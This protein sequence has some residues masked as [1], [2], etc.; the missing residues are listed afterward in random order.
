[1]QWRKTTVVVV[2][3]V[4][5]HPTTSLVGIALQPWPVLTLRCGQVWESYRECIGPALVDIG[6]PVV[7][8]SWTQKDR[9]LSGALQNSALVISNCQPV[10]GIPE[11]KVPAKS[12]Q[13]GL[14]A[15]SKIGAF[16]YTVKYTQKVL[17][18][19]VLSAAMC[20]E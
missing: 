12:D 1:M 20:Q 6:L 4:M 11:V 3:V 16:F 9:Y 14:K 19:P 15:R 13:F 7:R 2:V 17:Y 10:M 5:L 18:H 8:K